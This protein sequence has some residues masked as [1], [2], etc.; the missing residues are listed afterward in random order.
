MALPRTQRGKDAIMVVVDRFSK[1][2]QC[3][4]CYKTDD[5]SYIVDLYFKEMI[6]LYG[7][8]KIIVFDRDFKFLSYFWRSVWKFLG[9]KL[10]FSTAYHPQ[11]DGQIEV[12]N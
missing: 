11:T 10:L 1:M 3:I 2:A 12:T 9:T 5:A 7:V 8:P 4:P 6:R